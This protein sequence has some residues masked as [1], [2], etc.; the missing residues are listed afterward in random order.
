MFKEKDPVLM[1]FQVVTI[2]LKLV[3]V[4]IPKDLKMV[5]KESNHM[6]INPD[7]MVVLVS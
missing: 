7:F 4:L 2:V 3:R 5:M 1:G 6:V